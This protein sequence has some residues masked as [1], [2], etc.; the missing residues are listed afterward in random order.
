MK[1]LIWSMSLVGLL[2]GSAQAFDYVDSRGFRHWNHD[3]D[4]RAEPSKEVVQNPGK[5]TVIQ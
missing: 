4:Q 1:S 5:R 2:T 3:R